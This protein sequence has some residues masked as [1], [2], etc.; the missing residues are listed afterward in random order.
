MFAL[1]F[2]SVTTFKF[3][4]FAQKNFFVGNGSKPYMSESAKSPSAVKNFETEE[5]MT[6]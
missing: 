5:L 6:A 2:A 3:F 4:T 1:N